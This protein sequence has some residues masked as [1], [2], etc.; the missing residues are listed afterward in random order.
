MTIKKKPFVRY[1]LDEELNKDDYLF[2]IRITKKDKIWFIPALNLLKQQQ[3]STGMKQLAEIGA[4]IVLHDPKTS[5]I[6]DIV[7]NNSRKN[8]RK[9]LT[10]FEN[11]NEIFDKCNTNNQE[12]VTQTKKDIHVGNLDNWEDGKLKN[13]KGCI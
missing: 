1:T 11:N 9:G 13:N 10:E 2:T 8:Q 3:Q 5:K 7:I 4:L 6:L 12:N